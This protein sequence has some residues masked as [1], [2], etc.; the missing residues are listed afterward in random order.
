MRIKILDSILHGSLKPWL[1]KPNYETQLT[2]VLYSAMPLHPIAF[3]DL[4]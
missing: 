4:H 3:F 1:M 2:K